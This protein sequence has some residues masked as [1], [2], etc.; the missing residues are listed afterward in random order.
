MWHEELL[1]KVIVH[2]PIW[3]QHP[4]LAE[5]VQRFTRTLCPLILQHYAGRAALGGVGQPLTEDERE[6]LPP[7]AAPLTADDYEHFQRLPD[8]S[9]ATH[10]INGAFAAYRLAALLPEDLAWD[11]ERWNLWTLGFVLHDYG[12]ARG[13]EVSAS[14]LDTVRV[15]CRK[16]GAEL[17]FEEFFPGWTDYLDDIVF[18][19]QNTQAFK[20]TNLNPRDYAT[21]Y[22]FN[23][24]DPLRL[25]AS[26]A[27]VLVHV[28]E[29]R[30][31]AGRAA[32]TNRP[33]DIN[34]QVKLR[35]LLGAERVPRLAYHQMAETRG[36]LTNIL[37]NAAQE[38]MLK[39]GFRPYLYFADGMVYLAPQQTSGQASIEE[40]VERAWQDIVAAFTKSESFGL[41]RDGKGLKVAPPLY[42]FL[43][44]AGL[45]AA[46]RSYLVQRVSD[47][48]SSAPE[49]LEKLGTTDPA[50]ARDFR[51]DWLGEYLAY[52]KRNIAE[53]LLPKAQDLSAFLLSQLELDGVVSAADAERQSGGVPLGWYYAAAHYITRHPTLAQEEVEAF[54]RQVGAAFLEELRR[55]GLPEQGVG[56]LRSALADYVAKTLDL[57]GAAL[58]G[59]EGAAPFANELIGYTGNKAS[60]RPVC[61]LCSSPYENEEQTVSV[62]IFKPQQY[63]NKNR[64]GGSQVVRG[65]CPICS[66]EMLLRQATQGATAGKLQDQK[67]IYLALYPAYFFTPE[68]A[69]LLQQ[70]QYRLKDLRLYRGAESLLGWLRK[71]S[72]DGTLN[73]EH[74]SRYEQFLADEDDEAL[75]QI[76]RHTIRLPPLPDYSQKTLSGLA[77]LPLTPPVSDATD[78]EAWVLP[79]FYALA[80]P[81]L[82]NVKVVASASFVPLYTS[83]A[84]FRETVILDS[85]HPTVQ[86]AL[87]TDRLRI[88]EIIPALKRLLS[89]YDLHT[90]VFAEGFDAHWGQLGAVVRDVLTDAY[91]VFVYYDRKRRAGGE[92][93]GEGSSNAA[94]NGGNGP[95]REGIPLWEQQK[96]LDIYNTLGGT[97]DMGVI[98]KLVDSYAEFYRADFGKLSSGYAVLK[99][100]RTAIDTTTNSSP[101]LAKDDLV[102]I[103]SGELNDLMERI[104][105]GQAD[106]WN[107]ITTNKALGTWPE[108]L[109]QSRS[110]IQAFAQQFVDDLFVGLCQEDRATLR[111]MAN[112]LNSAARFHYLTHYAARARAESEA[113]AAP[114]ASK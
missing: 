39:H 16:L 75:P 105:D 34:L 109:A 71:A 36:L 32:E 80:L 18:L 91:N 3:A 29:P 8:Q 10:L 107:P 62:V 2:D 65:I 86:Q 33:T 64:L 78:T 81:L 9:L 7:G 111:E 57:D 101:R 43:D 6:A 94:T 89:F 41:G 54:M 99:P 82:L 77:L 106:G 87:G 72:Q 15:I 30:D 98:G 61:S 45:I 42:E 68:M 63:S 103:I 84:A 11:T 69:A 56:T 110:K 96:Y 24:L 19:A 74:L 55:Q 17:K 60:N 27:D 23:Q 104:Q 76:K 97:A 58:T 35:M 40:V 79:A 28:T 20:G 46:G 25:L 53:V 108:R 26:F 22:R 70:Y 21:R 47:K 66:L 37:H 95:T 113:S 67:A 50:L 48:N 4:T 31:V 59:A 83:A 90:D 12:K 14:K 73:L 51:V 92:P 52:L 88:D 44:A 100:L 85:M 102:E 1:G 93:K 112:R 5:V 49:R 38:A 13:V 114:D